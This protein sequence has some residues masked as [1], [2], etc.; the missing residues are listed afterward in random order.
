MVW[1]SLVVGRNTWD[2]RCAV[3]AKVTCEESWNN[4]LEVPFGVII[5]CIWWLVTIAA[6]FALVSFVEH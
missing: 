6:I 2:G 3:V 5:V 4:L 1:V